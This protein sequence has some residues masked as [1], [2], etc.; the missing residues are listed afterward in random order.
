MNSTE[1]GM[2]D[3]KDLNRKYLR[4]SKIQYHE[5]AWESY[6]SPVKAGN[7]ENMRFVKGFLYKR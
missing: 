4:N 1:P 3:K 5:N 2:H 7:S 6:F